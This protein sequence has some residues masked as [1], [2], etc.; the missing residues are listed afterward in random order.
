MAVAKCIALAGS[1]PLSTFLEIDRAALRGPAEMPLRSKW[2]GI[3]RETGAAAERRRLRPWGAAARRHRSS[4]KSQGVY[5]ALQ[6][7][8]A[9]RLRSHPDGAQPE[10]LRGGQ[11]PASPPATAVLVRCTNTPTSSSIASS[12]AGS[13]ASPT[14]SRPR[15]VRPTLAAALLMPGRCEFLLGI[16]KGPAPRRERSAVFDEKEVAVEARSSRALRKSSSTRRRA[17]GAYYKVSRLAAIYRLRNLSARLARRAR[18]TAG[19]SKAG[20]RERIRAVAGGYRG[21]IWSKRKGAPGFRSRFL[22][23]SLEALRRRKISHQ[24]L[25]ELLPSSG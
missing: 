16:G 21:G 5:A 23:L 14:G 1:L 20:T 18:R 13:A 15:G 6:E 2:Q 10:L 7:A 19:R 3:E 4:T 9:R 22:T 8:A 11:P 24:K 25:L 17:A 12:G